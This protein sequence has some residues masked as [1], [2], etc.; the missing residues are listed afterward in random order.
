MKKFSVKTLLI[1]PVLT[2]ML[3]FPVATTSAL[4]A[5]CNYQQCESTGVTPTV[6]VQKGVGRVLSLGDR[7]TSVNFLQKQLNKVLHTHIK[8][9]GVFGRET[10][11][12]VI[13]LQRLTGELRTGVV[14]PQTWSAALAGKYRVATQVSVRFGDR[15]PLVKVVQQLL[16]RHGYTTRID[17]VFGTATWRAVV[18]F[19]AEV[20]LSSN[21]KAKA[22]VSTRVWNALNLPHPTPA[23]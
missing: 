11:A 18:A 8:V 23:V 17:G 10:K 4:A 5:T 15:G 2:G 21:G 14:V 13:Q 12:A 3:A 16:N 9:D 22:V 6:L 7:G 20:G 19:K 1:A